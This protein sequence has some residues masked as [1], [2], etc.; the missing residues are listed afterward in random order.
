MNLPFAKMH[1]LGNDFVVFDATREPV[2]SL[3]Q[4]PPPALLRLLT[5]RRFGVGCDQVLLIEPAPDATVDF[6]YRIFNADGSE[7]GQCGNGSRCLARYV[8]DHGLSRKRDLRVK[9]STSLLELHLLDDGQVR[10]N[11][12]APRFEPAEIP[13]IVHGN[14]SRSPEYSLTLADGTALACGAVS[15]GNPHAV[16]EVADVDHAPVAEVGE[17]L[18]H[19]PAFPQRVNAGFVQFVDSGHARLR[20][21]ER[22]AGE[23]L[24]CGSGACAAMVVGRVWGKLGARA[25]IQVRGGTLQLEW[26]GEGQPVW[27]TGPAETV[28]EGSLVWPK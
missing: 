5:D 8:H 28:F 13:M 15:M 22:G 14:G 18:Q 10:V 26:A 21:H 17:E 3:L 23:T 27:M 25:A 19:H 11:M 16:I 9:T 24:A 7:V 6:G 2:H 12:G 4:A 1:G 20:V